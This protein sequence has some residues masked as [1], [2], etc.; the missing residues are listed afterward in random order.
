MARNNDV[1]KTLRLLSSTKGETSRRQQLEQWHSIF[2]A[3]GNYLP[4]HYLATRENVS[5]VIDIA[6]EQNE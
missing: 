6:V 3:F 1:S 4:C 5:L 2:F